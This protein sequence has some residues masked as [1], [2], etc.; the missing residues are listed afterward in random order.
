ME[1]NFHFP[2]L[3]VPYLDLPQQFPDLEKLLNWTSLDFL[4]MAA[5]APAPPAPPPVTSSSIEVPFGQLKIQFD[6]FF[7]EIWGVAQ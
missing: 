6:R 3:P 7:T 1:D 4:K 5:P 2:G